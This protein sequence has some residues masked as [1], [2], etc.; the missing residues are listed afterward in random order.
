MKND[1]NKRNRENNVRDFNF[2]GSFAV[3]CRNVFN[4]HSD[5]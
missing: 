4:G 2:T 5:F 1:N 3:V